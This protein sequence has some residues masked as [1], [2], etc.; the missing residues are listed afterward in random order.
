[1][2]SPGLATRGF[3]VWNACFG[4]S[5]WN[6]DRLGAGLLDAETG[7]VGAAEVEWE[8]ALVDLVA[9]FP[10]AAA[11]VVRDGAEAVGFVVR[12]DFLLPASTASSSFLILLAFTGD[13]S[14]LI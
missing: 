8:E 11:V 13:L 10:L 1:M 5:G 12:A 3:G 2:I 14:S 9:F 6:L 7:E 4:K